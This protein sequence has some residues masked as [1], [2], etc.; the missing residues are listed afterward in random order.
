MHQ[1]GH[2]FGSLGVTRS[3]G[4]SSA[5]EM[6]L[7]LAFGYFHLPFVLTS[8]HVTYLFDIYQ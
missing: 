3:T 7:I 2:F 1:G 4:S 6:E 8:R 5:E